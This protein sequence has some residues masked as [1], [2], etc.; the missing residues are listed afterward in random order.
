[1]NLREKR[2]G[3]EKRRKRGEDPNWHYGQHFIAGRCPALRIEGT[4]V[5]SHIACL[6]K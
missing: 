4:C 3:E 6:A 2:E 5:D 1:L